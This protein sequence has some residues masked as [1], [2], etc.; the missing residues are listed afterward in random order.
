MNLSILF[1]IFLGYFAIASLPQ[2]ILCLYSKSKGMSGIFSLLILLWALY[3]YALIKVYDSKSQEDFYGYF[4]YLSLAP[5]LSG[6][7]Q[8]IF[9]SFYTNKFYKLLF[10][11]AVALS[12][13]CFTLNLF[14]LFDVISVFYID[15]QFLN[16]LQAFFLENEFLISA[17]TYF[18]SLPFVILYTCKLLGEHYRSYKKNE[19]QILFIIF[20]SQTLLMISTFFVTAVTMSIPLLEFCSLTLIIS[21]SIFISLQIKNKEAVHTSILQQKKMRLFKDEIIHFIVTDFKEPLDMLSK[22]T[23]IDSKKAIVSNV[24]SSAF[25]IQNA[26]FNMLDVYKYDQSEIK[27]SRSFCSL[28]RII[29]CSVLRLNLILVEKNIDIRLNCPDDYNVNVD[30]NVIERA[31]VNFLGS[32][33]EV[34]NQNSVIEIFINQLQDGKLLVKISCVGARLSEERISTYTR[35]LQSLHSD[36]YDSRSDVLSL[37]FCKMVIEAHKGEIGFESDK[38][39]NHVIWFT[40]PYG[41]LKGILA[42]EIQGSNQCAPD[43]KINLTNNEKKNI[44]GYYQMLAETQLFEVTKLRVLITEFEKNRK[45]NSSWLS[46]LKVSI[47]EMDKDKYMYLIDMINPNKW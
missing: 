27:L 42:H 1:Y 2:V 10:W 19:T 11:F 23:S 17:V 40:L 37:L 45:I 31:F 39:F 9:V 25:K 15:R 5:T 46:E 21:V 28:K 12:I 43:V 35:V 33:A 6:I 14:F 13:T 34:I 26:V 16:K 3:E 4:K 47:R 8:V 29:D 22:I 20:G 38:N 44:V 32:F 18:L 30:E 41:N 36:L 24:K 7:L